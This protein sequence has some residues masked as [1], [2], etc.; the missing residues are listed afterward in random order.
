[1]RPPV[2]ISE[3]HIQRLVPEADWMLSDAT[4][5]NF[6]IADD[7]AGGILLPWQ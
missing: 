3:R 6:R 1:M 4:S 7:S 2:E 5:A